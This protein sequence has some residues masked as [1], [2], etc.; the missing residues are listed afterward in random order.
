MFKIIL[1]LKRNP[2]YSVKDFQSYWLEKHGPLVTKVPGV[3]RYVQ[4]HPLPQGYAKGELIFDGMAELWFESPDAFAAA[5]TTSQWLAVQRDGDTFRDR[6]RI[7]VMPV[8]VHVIK[9][10]TIP[11]NAVKNIE[12]VNRRPD[13]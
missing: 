12:F 10:G 13:M 7:V 8:D 3:K 9:D 2:G 6:S 1:L 11:E 4:S 5:R